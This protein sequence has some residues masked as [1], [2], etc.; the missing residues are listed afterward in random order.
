M[1]IKQRRYPATLNSS[2]AGL[3]TYNVNVECKIVAFYRI[4]FRKPFKKYR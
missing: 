2:K 3:K 4:T 1:L